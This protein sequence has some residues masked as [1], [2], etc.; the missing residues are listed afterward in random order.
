MTSFSNREKPEKILSFL[1]FIH[2]IFTSI[3]NPSTC[4]RRFKKTIS[5]WNKFTNYSFYILSLFVVSLT[6]YGKILFFRIACW[7]FSS[8]S[9]SVQLLFIWNTAGLICYCLLCSPYRY[10]ISLLFIWVVCVR[11]RI[12]SMYH[13]AFFHSFYPIH[14][15]PL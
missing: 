15:I 6:I 5:V 2:S 11:V 3:L 14:H 8:P 4:V 1:T 7:V 12:W 13:I 10:W 9:I